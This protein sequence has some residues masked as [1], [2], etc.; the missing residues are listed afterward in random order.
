MEGISLNM[1]FH[2]NRPKIE[3]DER[4]KLIYKLRRI[5]IHQKWRWGWLYSFDDEPPVTGIYRRVMKYEEPGIIILNNVTLPLGTGKS[6]NAF[7]MAKWLA[8]KAG[9]DFSI[10][11]NIFFSGKEFLERM[12]K[13]KEPGEAL[14]WDEAGLG[15]GHARE[16]RDP[17]NNALNEALRLSRWM[18]PFIFF[19]C[20]EISL[21]DKNTR[22]LCSIECECMGVDKINSEALAILKT[23]HWEQDKYGRYILKEA[24]MREIPAA[25]LE[26]FDENETQKMKAEPYVTFDNA[27]GLYPDEWK[28]Y[29]ELKR[30]ALQKEDVKEKKPK[31]KYVTKE[32]FTKF[33]KSIAHK[34]K[35]TSL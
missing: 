9:T 19:V 23:L 24:G 10:D 5:N 13:I 26:S 28:R 2:N 34:R 17:L 25:W 20:P 29:L 33:K 8:E 21:I 16:W 1:G 31:E 15:G 3:F 12:K 32:D 6:N 18:Q 7:L 4:D 27:A 35:F 22:V 14:I 30:E 11:N